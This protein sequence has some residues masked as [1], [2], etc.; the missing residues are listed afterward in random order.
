MVPAASSCAVC[1]T[2]TNVGKRWRLRAISTSTDSA[3]SGDVNGDGIDDLVVGAP[4]HAQLAASRA[5]QSFVVFGST[6]RFPP[7]LNLA[8]L[9]GSNGFIVDGIEAGDLCGSAVAGAGDINGDGLDDVL[10]G[11]PNAWRSDAK[12]GEVLVVFGRGDGF[13]ARVGPE[14]YDGTHGF[15]MTGAESGDFGHSV[16][17]VGDVNDDDIDDFVVGAP[18]VAPAARSR[19]G[20]A[21]VFFGRRDGFDAHMQSS[22]ADGTHGFR[23]D[24]ANAGD[25]AGWSVARAGDVNGDETADLIV[26]APS[27]TPDGRQRVGESYVIFGRAA[28]VPILLHGLSA[29][30]TSAGVQL[31]WELGD[32]VRATWRT[33]VQRALR[34]NDSFTTIHVARRTDPGPV[35]YL[36]RAAPPGEPWYRIG[37]V[38]EQ[39]DARATLWIGAARSDASRRTVLHPPRV[40]PTSGAVDVAYAIA[41][42]ALDV[43]LEVFDARGR[44]V[45]AFSHVPGATGEHVVRW[46]GDERR[47]PTGIF[48]LVLRTGRV[49]ESRRMLLLARE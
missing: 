34:R 6:D 20:S 36:D 18:S 48:W 38:D 12:R 3:I 45:H 41:G 15:R 16:S 22:D 29:R 8:T 23:I 25:Q 37:L 43:R 27:V 33:L 4:L 31:S 9:D 40:D 17:G 5:G 24:G 42:P 7:V 39:G 28:R 11:C 46:D 30:R 44:R 10:F 2:E 21:Y 47:H 1:T 32:G 14:Y 13:P 19:A 26:G 35:Q 49:L